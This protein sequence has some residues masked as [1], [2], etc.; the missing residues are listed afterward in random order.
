MKRNLKPRGFAAASLVLVFA[1]GT[2]GV[3]AQD[4]PTKAIRMV[5]GFPPGG[6]TDFLSRTIGQKLTEAWGQPVIVDNRPGVSSNLGA[7]IAAR[8]TPD[9]YTLFMGL[10]SVLAPSM[11]LYP[12]LKYNLLTDLTPVSLVATGAY[13][14]LVSSSIQVNSVRDLIAL[15]K[16]KPG[17]L[18]YASS[19]V[20]SPA[21][22]AGELFNLRAGVN[23]VHVAYKGGAPAALALGTGESQ[24]F[25]GSV[26]ASLPLMN[27]GKAKALAVTTPNPSRG[28]PGVPTVS[29]SGLPGFDITVS[30]GILAPAGTPQPIIAKLNQEI[31]RI[32]K[33]KP[34]IDSL[35]AFGLD[36]KGGSPQDFAKVL[37]DE[38]T[39]WSKVIEE[40][41]IRLN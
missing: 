17:Q 26:A 30:Y 12:D 6:G 38:V 1:A 22:L 15:A 10:A 28:L 18:N 23:I 21:H 35:T 37:R 31:G 40:A 34:V 41:K 16:S 19:G 7:E 27:T 14:L 36:A 39:L 9:G 4:Y 20:G 25:Y 2:T 29:E 11:K 5:D 32:L 3:C 13:V 24:L 8:S 33:S